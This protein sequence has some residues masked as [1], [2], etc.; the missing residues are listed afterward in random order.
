MTFFF[1]MMQDKDILNFWSWF[2]KNSNNLH[3]DNYDKNILNELDTII[4]DWGLTWEIGPGLSKDYS[5]TISPN[6]DKKLLD[7]TNYIIDKALS[8]DNWEFYGFKQPKEI[9]HLATLGDTGFQINASNWS[10]VLL[11]YEDEKIEIL[12]KADSLAN[13]DPETKELVADLILTNLLGEKIK[14]EKIDFIDIVESFEN[15]KGIT[16]LKFLTAH[17][18]DKKYFN[19]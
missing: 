4:S 13:L 2:A 15:E 5:L 3:S 11:K 7:T 17:L 10:Y 18:T 8:L 9:W 16:E 19:S 1:P 6:G 14:I 12:L